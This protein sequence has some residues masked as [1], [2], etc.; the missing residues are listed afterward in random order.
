[1][2]KAFSH[3]L[4]I[5]RLPLWDALKQRR[6]PLSFTFEV[7]ARCNNDC[8]H[9][10][11]NLPAADSQAKADELSS[12]EILRIAEQA[13]DMGALWCLLTGGEPLLR[14]DFPEIYLS[15]KRKGLLVSVFTNATVI[16]P[17]HIQLFKSYP[18]RDLEVTVY[19]VTEAT[20]DA[21]TRRSGSFAAFQR[22]LQLLLSNGLP[23]N[24]KTMAL[25][26]NLHELPQI[27]EFC[28]SHTKGYYRF[29]PLLHL[30][31][32]RDP[33]RNA[34]I[35]RERLT[36]EEIVFLEKTDPERFTAMRTHCDEFLAPVTGPIG[37]DRLF[38]C[39]A[40]IGEFAVSYKGIFRLCESLW[41][42]E[43]IYDLRKGPLR[44][45]WDDLVPRV[46]DLRSR[47][48]A[49]QQTCHICSIID[50]CLSCP[51]HTY[52]ETGE[53][54]KE[55]PYFCEVARARARMLEESKEHTGGSCGSQKAKG[56]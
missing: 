40:G 9:C 37:D 27:A 7:T 47:R 10:Y 17:E 6:A 21:V 56:N 22:G 3:S 33:Q 5:Q 23:V 50:L 39:G 44:Q 2:E 18:P 19:G 26:S 12:E 20:Y 41:A 15:L 42:P 1:M 49:F 45:A 52:L 13:V 16:R 25:R 55:T 4:E 48:P 28:R 30:R 11:I 24:L 34:L 43:T 14:P 53:M 51:A 29:D 31:Y 54:D 38:H 35:R 46:R 32:D 8:G 36:P